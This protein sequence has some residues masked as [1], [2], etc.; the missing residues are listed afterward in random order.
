MFFLVDVG[1]G[2]GDVFTCFIRSRRR[3]WTD[4]ATRY[5]VLSPNRHM[6]VEKFPDL[7]CG[8]TKTTQFYFTSEVGEYMIEL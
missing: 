5:N 1:C 2:K 3:K 7:S 4:S 8:T 6:V